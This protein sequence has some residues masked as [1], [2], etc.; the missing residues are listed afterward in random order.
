MSR[1][2]TDIATGM[3]ARTLAAA[4]WA[5]VAL[6]ITGCVGGSDDPAPGN[7]TVSRIVDG[8][9]IEVVLNGSTERVRL[10]GIDTPEIAHDAFGDRPAN[11]AECFGDEATAF[12]TSLVPVGATVRLERDVVG[13]DDYGRLLAYVYRESDGVF[14][15][16]EMVR[17]GFAQPMSIP[18]N[19]TYRALMVQ[20]ARDAA[21]DR[22]GLWSACR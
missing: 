16:Y 1:T 15:N 13:R 22:A 9:T 7:A 3:L 14:V 10:I 5:L 21:D 6:A 4:T 20:A 11:D 8:D 12:I 17:Q 18:P 19:T 2:R